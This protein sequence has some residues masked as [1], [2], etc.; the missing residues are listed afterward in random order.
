MLVHQ[1]VS[2]RALDSFQSNSSYPYKEV[3]KAHHGYVQAGSPFPDWGYLCKTEAGEASHW[4]PFIEAYKQYLEKTYEKGSEPYNRLVAF[5][6]GIESHI[7][8]DIIWH[9]GKST[10]TAGD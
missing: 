2:E 8:A 3:L 9:W 10:S 5:L 6:F 4:P 7:E 1:D